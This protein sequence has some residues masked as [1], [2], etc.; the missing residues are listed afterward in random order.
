MID[1]NMNLSEHFKLREFLCKCGQCEIPPTALHNIQDIARVME[2]VRKL[3]GNKPITI[4][5][6]YRCPEHNRKIGGAPNS[7]HMRGQA[8][9]FVVK[10]VSP[11]VTQSLLKDWRGGLELTSGWTHLD[12]GPKRRFK[13]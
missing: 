5:S 12:T 4:T 6:G 11:K 7:Y 13:P 8:A 10:G 9:D 1:P 3:H 2:D